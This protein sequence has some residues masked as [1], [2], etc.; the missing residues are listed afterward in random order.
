VP[1]TPLFSKILPSFSSTVTLL[2]VQEV[3]ARTEKTKKKIELILFMAS[4]HLIMTGFCTT[5]FEP[6]VSHESNNGQRSDHQ[7]DDAAVQTFRRLVSELLCGFGTNGTLSGCL[8]G[9]RE[10]DQKANDDQCPFHIL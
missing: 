10:A 7:V 2:T 6:S 9:N 1:F 5:A 3:K 8:M 4:V